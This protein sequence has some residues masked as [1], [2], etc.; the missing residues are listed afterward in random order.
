MWKDTL[1][2][3]VAASLWVAA[4]AL[5]VMATI[6]RDSLVLSGWSILLAMAGSV[7]ICWQMMIHERTRVTTIAQLVARRQQEQGQGLHQV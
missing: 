5:M 1:R 2:I 7:L 4:V 3:A 6:D